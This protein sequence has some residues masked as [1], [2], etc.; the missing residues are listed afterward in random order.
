MKYYQQQSDARIEALEK[1]G[2]AQ[3]EAFDKELD[4][5]ENQRNKKLI[6]ESTYEAKSAAI[7]EQR[8]A[9]EKKIEAA[10]A[11]EKRK[12]AELAKTLA[13]FKATLA[14]A[15]AIAE[16]NYYGAILAAAE[17]AIIIA[18]PIPAFKKGT[19][20]KKDSGTA[21]VGEE[22]PEFVNLPQGAQVVPHKQ[23]VKNKELVNAMIDDDVDYYIFKNYT[24]PELLKSGT[25]P[26][27]N[28]GG[29]PINNSSTVTTKE[30]KR[31]VSE[32]ISTKFISEIMQPVNNIII[33]A[34]QENEKANQ[35]NFS[36]SIANAI[37]NNVINNGSSLDEYGVRRALNNGTKIKNAREIG[38]AIA[39]ELKT[40]VDYRHL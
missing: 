15:V 24:L 18:T 4:S 31:V 10:I 23:T 32:T 30:L 17:L 39:Q 2:D 36:N 22:G 9:A 11:K 6:S 33:Q 27:R 8:V 38:K 29:S 19:K 37:T 25:M 14:I 16:E 21:L 5:L 13:I 3:T 40:E 34:Q 35:E 12:A 1:Q 7:K 28:F 26:Q 20:G